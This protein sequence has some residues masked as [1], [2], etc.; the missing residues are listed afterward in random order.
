M[1]FIVGRI[2]FNNEFWMDIDVSSL[3]NPSIVDC[4]VIIDWIFSMTEQ[5]ID[6]CYFQFLSFTNK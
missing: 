6:P 4:Y 3:K 1:Y 2:G 5:E